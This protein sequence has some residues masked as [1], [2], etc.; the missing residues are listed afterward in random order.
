LSYEK[1]DV[2]TL[3]AIF[4]KVVRELIPSLEEGGKL[5]FIG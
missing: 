2:E 3:P 4:S 1:L 5:V